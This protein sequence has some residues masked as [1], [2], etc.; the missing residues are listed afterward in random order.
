MLWELERVPESGGGDVNSASN[1][2]TPIQSQYPETLNR[3][4]LSRQTA[5][6]SERGG[7]EDYFSSKKESGGHEGRFRRHRARGVCAMNAHYAQDE[8]CCYLKLPAVG[9]AVAAAILPRQRPPMPRRC[10][11]PHQVVPIPVPTRKSV[12]VKPWCGAVCPRHFGFR[13]NIE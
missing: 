13:C 6:R 3:S 12:V 10:L 5:N 1:R 11:S 8:R 9:M 4:G 2:A 7:R